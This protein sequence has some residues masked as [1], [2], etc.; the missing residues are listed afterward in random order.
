MGVRSW[1]APA[2]AIAAAV[3]VTAGAV[4]VAG[5]HDP[6]PV[7]ASGATDGALAAG[8]AG[9]GGL[10]PAVTPAGSARFRPNMVVIVADD[11]DSSLVKYM[12]NVQRLRKRGAD[13]RRH[14]VVD[15]LCCSSRAA[16]LTGM[17][18]H[19][20]KVFNNV[21]GPDRS[22]PTGGYAA[23]LKA[24]N[25]AKTF[26]YAINR[27]GGG[28]YHTGF[29]G[30]FI[31]LYQGS[32]GSAVP[33][34]W[35]TFNA[36]SSSRMYAMWGYPMTSVATSASGARVVARHFYGTRDRDYSTDVLRRMSVAHINRVERA[37]K[38]YFVEIAPTATHFRV[39]KPARKGDNW[40]PA[41]PRDLPRKG[42]KARKNPRLRY[43]DCGTK[44]C[45]RIDVRK[46]PGFN[47]S[48]APSRPRY[49][50][51]RLAPMFGTTKKLPRKQV[52]AMQK[53]Y[54]DRVRMA[55]SL[56]DLVG[57]VMRSVGPDTY[58]A[59][60][61]DNGY[62]MGHKRLPSGKSSP[63]DTDIRVPLI[64]AGP[65]VVRGPRYQVV[66][67]I[68]LAS[69]FEHIAGRTPSQARDGRSLLPILRN[70]RA[71]WSR[72]AFL[73]HTRP[74]R[75]VDDPD[76][77]GWTPLVPSYVAV[78]SADKLLVR[79]DTLGGDPAGYTYEYYRGLTRKGA[80]ER[81][82][83]YNPTDPEI[84]AMRSRIERFKE[85]AGARCRDLAR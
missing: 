56:D 36:M 60:T 49:V 45:E 24:K 20:T 41:A 33:A 21:T 16:F 3:V 18:P 30:K 59:F 25:D 37:G 57:A 38:P 19:N 23:W 74:A 26:A 54:R 81:T 28:S 29:F 79:Y 69:T 55:Q 6:M 82:N 27:S 72:Y 7:S 53:R 78:R 46:L 71:S 75:S 14:F 67:S 51:G 1:R 17:Y 77:E 42:K 12:P 80:W 15:S 8:A 66:Q 73:E 52:K 2:I 13:F 48:R 62:H 9:T 5:A 83:T 76:G 39:G 58:I 43:G 85:C 63:Y 44:R 50:D 4:V 68:D 22:N 84:L 10:A 61:S 64:I 65:G 31:N 11:L 47:A 70:P 35:N 32:P 34:G 40:F